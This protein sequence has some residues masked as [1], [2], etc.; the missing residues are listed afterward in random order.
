MFFIPNKYVLV[1][2]N[3]CPSLRGGTLQGP[4]GGGDRERLRSTE[5]ENKLAGRD[6]DKW[7]ENSSPQET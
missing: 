2:T 5:E 3:Y 1:L 7:E 4:S 6:G